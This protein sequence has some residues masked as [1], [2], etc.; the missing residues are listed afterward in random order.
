MTIPNYVTS[1]DKLAKAV[2]LHN[3]GRFDEA[4][5][6]YERLAARGAKAWEPRYLLG[7][8][9]FQQGEP[10]V[11]QRWLSDA[12]RLNARH[13]DGWFYLGES[14]AAQGQLAQAEAAYVKAST[15]AKPHAMANFKLGLLREGRG[16]VSEAMRAY[17]QALAGQ[18]DFP[19]ALN[20]LAHL[21]QA[22]G[23]VPQAETL[24]R[25]ALQDHPDFEPAYINL[26]MLLAESSGGLHAAIELL[27]AGVAKRPQ[28][29]DLQFHLAA[30]LARSG[31]RE[32]AV[33]HYEQALALNPDHA[34]A[35]NNVGV[36]FLDEGFVEEARVC[37]ERAIEKA[38]LVEAY[39]N[40]GSLLSRLEQFD[41]ALTAV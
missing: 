39:N 40:L 5:R 17:R 21:L 35:Y 15:Q 36:L 16:A 7:L 10:A 14:L 18:A 13:A 28:S 25:Q 37:F 9:H 19:E 23:D 24:Y 32:A 29:A 41:A 22:G 6:V 2:E 27:S 31:H 26:A 12:T 8:L 34:L 11:A 30:T 20:N 33:T 3:R 38:E 4:A 1:Q